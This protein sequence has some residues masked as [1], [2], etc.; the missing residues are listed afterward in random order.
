MMT[1]QQIN[2]LCAELDGMARRIGCRFVP[3][4]EKIA[5]Y[6]ARRQEIGNGYAAAIRQVNGFPAT[7]LSSRDR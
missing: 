6:K 5:A 2:E 7:K 1:D 4:P 3:D